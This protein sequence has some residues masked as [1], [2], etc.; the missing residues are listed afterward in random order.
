MIAL[1]I[2]QVDFLVS[3]VEIATPN[4]AFLLT[5]LINVFIKSLIKAMSKIQALQFSTGVGHI[6][7]DQI[8]IRIL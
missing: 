7:I 5:K 4:D 3:H 2:F 8:E 1:R 6:G